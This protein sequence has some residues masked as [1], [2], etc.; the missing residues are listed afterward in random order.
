MRE[1]D[2]KWPP[3]N[4]DGMQELAIKIGKESISFQ[5]S[6]KWCNNQLHLFWLTYTADRKDRVAHGCVRIRR[7]RRSASLLL[8]RT[9]SQSACVL[10]DLSSLQGQSTT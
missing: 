5:V 10:I 1:D 8:S 2:S 6:E 3:K 7:P 4:K 9:G